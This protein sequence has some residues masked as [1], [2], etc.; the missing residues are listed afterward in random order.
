MFSG[1]LILD[2]EVF[3]IK[4]EISLRVVVCRLMK[5]S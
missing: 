5:S 2:L 3:E 1:L 4:L